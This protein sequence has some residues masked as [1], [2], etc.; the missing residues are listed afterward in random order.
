M[1]T[2]TNKGALYD[3]TNSRPIEQ[4]NLSGIYPTEFKVVI[5]PDEVNNEHKFK[6][7]SGKEFKLYKPDDTTEREQ[8]AQ[9]DGVIVAV[10]GLAFTYAT[11][12]EWDAGG[13]SPPKAGDRVSFA[14][15]AGATRL[16]KD[17]KTYR[18]VNDK[19]IIA[20]LA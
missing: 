11:R 19:D 15:Y 3:V 14:K 9:Q 5:L 8:F 12:A 10:S 13:C 7:Q 17:S 16:G 20:V 1:K 18:V 4:P 6:G 2:E